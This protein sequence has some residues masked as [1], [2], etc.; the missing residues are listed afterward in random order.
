[1]FAVSVEDPYNA[2]SRRRVLT[3]P[4]TRHGDSLCCSRARRQGTTGR[5]PPSMSLSGTE[6]ASYL[7]ALSA[8]SPSSSAVPSTCSSDIHSFI[9]SFVHSIN[10]SVRQS[11]SQSFIHWIIHLFVFL[12]SESGNKM[13]TQATRTSRT[14]RLTTTAALPQI[15]IWSTLQKL[16][17]AECPNNL[18]LNN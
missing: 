13:T 7:T 4:L 2:Y 3:P 17:K 6:I 15:I 18:T 10:Q 1:M 5:W 12:V 9:H 8:T 11:V 14:T 16:T